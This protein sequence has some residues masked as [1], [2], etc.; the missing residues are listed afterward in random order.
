[1]VVIA[2]EHKVLDAKPQPKTTEATG[3]LNKALNNSGEESVRHFQRELAERAGRM[4]LRKED[5]K[6]FRVPLSVFR[7]YCKSIK[8]MNFELQELIL[9]ALGLRLKTPEEVEYLESQLKLAKKLKMVEKIQVLEEQ[10]RVM[11]DWDMFA[12]L[13]ALLVF[14]AVTY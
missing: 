10:L 4:K 7:V 14:D 3:K 2:K 12:R 9:Q 13:N 1:M 11:V 6:D 8:L 5:L